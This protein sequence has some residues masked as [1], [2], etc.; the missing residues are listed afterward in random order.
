MDTLKL[1]STKKVYTFG[2]S[3]QFFFG[4]RTLEAMI[5]N[6]TVEHFE[7]YLKHQ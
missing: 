2:Y 6:I 7:I 4:S 5:M 3:A 1:E